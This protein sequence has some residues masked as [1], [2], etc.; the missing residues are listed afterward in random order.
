MDNEKA[1]VS[2]KFTINELNFVLSILGKQ[3]WEGVNTI[4]HK[5]V[6]DAQNQVPVYE[7]DLEQEA[8]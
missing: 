2:I 8:A 7:Q 5:I 4:I 1:T 3:P 6:E